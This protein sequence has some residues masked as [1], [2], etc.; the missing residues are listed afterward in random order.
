MAKI[1]RLILILGELSKELAVLLFAAWIEHR[2][3]NKSTNNRK[4]SD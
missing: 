1:E 2:R 4:P 3:K